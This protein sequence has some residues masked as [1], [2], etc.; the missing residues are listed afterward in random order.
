VENTLSRRSALK[1]LL[2]GFFGSTL[3]SKSQV[4]TLESSGKR[5]RVINGWVVP[6]RILRGSMPYDS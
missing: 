3:L 2:T 4:V 1:L 6:E 5:Y